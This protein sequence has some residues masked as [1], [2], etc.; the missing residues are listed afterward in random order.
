[1]EI[2]KVLIKRCKA[3]YSMCKQELE[4]KKGGK[5]R[6]RNFISQEIEKVKRKK[7]ELQS[8]VDDLEKKVKKYYDKAEKD[9]CIESMMKGNSFQNT[10]KEKIKLIPDLA[11]SLEELEKN[12]NPV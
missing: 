3:A 5:S 11:L 9:H 7:Q 8:F 2:D 12:K 1:M 4:D 6:K 10:V